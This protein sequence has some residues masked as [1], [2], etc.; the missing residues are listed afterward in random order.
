VDVASEDWEWIIECGNTNPDPV[1]EQVCI[2][3][4][5]IIIRGRRTD[6]TVKSERRHIYVNVYIARFNGTKAEQK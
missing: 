1:L 2:I 4:L 6:P 5:W 3:W